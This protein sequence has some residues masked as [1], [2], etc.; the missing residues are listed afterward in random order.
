MWQCRLHLSGLQ[1]RLVT[2]LC[3]Y[4]KEPSGR[5]TCE[6]SLDWLTFTTTFSRTSLFHG[7]CYGINKTGNERINVILKRVRVT[8]VAAESV[9]VCSLSYPACEAR[10]PYYVAIC[11]LSDCTTSFHITSKTFGEKLLN[12]K[13]VFFLYNCVWKISHYGKNLERYCHKFKSVFVW[14][15]RY[16]CQILMKLQ[17]SRHIFEKCFNIKFHENPSSGSRGVPCG[18]QGGRTDMTKL[19]P[20]TQPA[21]TSATTPHKDSASQEKKDNTHTQPRNVR[22]WKAI[23]STQNAYPTLSLNNTNM[24]YP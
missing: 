24:R 4:T 7:A 18:R 6:K 23:I 2:G 22:F 14:S 19:I 12:I 9:C 3:I 13:R 15:A 16:F 11:G 5:I 1:H 17:F 8:I 20:H 21:T 10:A